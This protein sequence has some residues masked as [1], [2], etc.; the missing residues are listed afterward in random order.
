MPHHPTIN[1]TFNLSSDEAADLAAFLAGATPSML[2]PLTGLG[3][4]PAVD[5]ATRLAAIL[6]R[7]AG[8]LEQ[9]DS[10]RLEDEFRPSVDCTRSTE[11]R[12]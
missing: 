2:A 12:D 5:M 3:G 8:A 4:R 10:H 6:G 11:G 7:L 9:A 1:I